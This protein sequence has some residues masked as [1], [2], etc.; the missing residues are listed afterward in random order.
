MTPGHTRG[1]QGRAC[2][3]WLK[4]RD[5]TKAWMK[6][7]IA[8]IVRADRPREHP[9]VAPVELHTF[10]RFERERSTQVSLAARVWPSH[11]TAWPTANDI[12]DEDTLRRAIGDALTQAHVIEDDDL[13]IGGVNLKRWCLP[14]ERAGVEIVVCVAPDPEALAKRERMLLGE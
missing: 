2:K 4:D 13:V 3:V 6:T 14:G 8:A 7:L 1:T 10:F 12:G 5:E 9:G 11:D